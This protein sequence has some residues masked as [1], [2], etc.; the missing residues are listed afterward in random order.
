MKIYALDVLECRNE[1]SPGSAAQAVRPLQYKH[2]LDCCHKLIT[3]VHTN[4]VQISFYSQGHGEMISQI[5]LYWQG[6]RKLI[7]QLVRSERMSLYVDPR[8]REPHGLFA[9][10]DILQLQLINTIKSRNTLICERVF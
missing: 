7:S 8:N 6:H 3:R 4:G 10:I 1:K 5:S 2:M 9:Q